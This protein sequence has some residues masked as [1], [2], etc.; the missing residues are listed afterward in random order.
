MRD[1]GRMI[2]L[3]DL[4]LLWILIMLNMRDIGL[5]ICNMDRVRKLGMKAL[6]STLDNFTKERR[7]EK[8]DFNGKIKAIMRE[9]LLMDSSKVSEFTTFQILIRLIRVN[10]E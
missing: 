1:H 3:M 2:R 7:M 10:L 9:T 6:Q 5:M 8:V 4:A